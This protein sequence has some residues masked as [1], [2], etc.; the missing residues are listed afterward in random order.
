[1]I[2]P[3]DQRG[4]NYSQHSAIDNGAQ[5]HYAGGGGDSDPRAFDRDTKHKE[6]LLRKWERYFPHESQQAFDVSA[7]LLTPTEK[8]LICELLMSVAK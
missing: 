1:M 6:K 8:L 3:N 4:I 5:N 7:F 2:D